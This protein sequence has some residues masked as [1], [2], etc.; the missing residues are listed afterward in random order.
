VRPALSVPKGPALSVS[1]G[2]AL[3]LSKGP[4]PP[5]AR[6][7]VVIVNYQSYRELR[8]CLDSLAG[9]PTIVVVD[10]E[11]DP[12][13][14]GEIAQSFPHVQ[15]LRTTRNDGFAAGVNRGARATDSSFLLLLNPD[16][17]IRADG[18]SVI[19]RWLEER[20]NVGAA[21]PRILNVDGTVQPS[22]RRFPDFTT[23]IA[24]RSSWL[25][26]VLPGNPLSRW[27]LPA[28]DTTRST[29]VDVDW[30]SGACM[31]AR[32]EAFD[33]VGGLDEGFFLYWEDA[34]FCRRLQQ[35]GWRTV[36]LP[37]ATA[38][39]TGGGSSRH[40]AVSSLRAFHRS[41]F[42][43]F[44]KHASPPARLLA[45][46]VFLGLQA[47]FNIMKLLLKR[48]SERTNRRRTR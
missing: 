46:F 35:A 43:L 28:R 11:S 23:A 8:R 4:P 3:S 37:A 2:P 42:R 9:H 32:R 44:W 25:T 1:K 27:N 5:A 20:P 34:D 21:G 6:V 40:A 13:A 16:C 7:A 29:P 14:S 30:I 17:I 47:R 10:H 45:P 22:A 31:M 18:C 39:H 19:A 41:A 15:L 12:E 33:A 48:N 26:K 38:T 36:Y 24:G